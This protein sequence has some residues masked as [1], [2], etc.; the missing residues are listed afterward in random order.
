MILS[1]NKKIKKFLSNI[2]SGNRSGEYEV[3][4]AVWYVEAT[5]NYEYADAAIPYTDFAYDSV[6]IT[7]PKTSGKITSSDVSDLYD[8][9]ID[10]LEAQY[11]DISSTNKHLVF[12]DVRLSS[13]DSEEA[14][15]CVYSGFTYGAP[16]NL[17]GNFY[18]YDNWYHDDGPDNDGGYCS[19][20]YIGQ[21]KE[22]DAAMELAKKIRYRTA[23]SSGRYYYSHI[24]TLIM[25]PHGT[26]HV[27]ET[28]SQYSCDF[29]NP[30][31]VTLEDNIMDY[32]IYQC[33]SNISTSNLHD[34]I[35]Y[36]EMN[37]YKTSHAE[38][39]DDI[40]F[41]CVNELMVKERERI[42]VTIVGLDGSSS[43]YTSYWHFT[44]AEYGKKHY[45]STWPNQF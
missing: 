39:I 27:D 37:F 36:N 40:V 4:S 16:F 11:D 24:I 32:M 29:L 33:N 6:F 12:A 3:D 34:C 7:A 8:E 1:L 2:Q 44:F 5:A 41:D 19:G 14:S 42:N 20:I 18:S 17:Y 31:D 30:D 23:A 43:S 26:V 15:F 13:E 25:Y 21:R 28:G 35:P 45:S 9:I 22:S 38:V 10:S